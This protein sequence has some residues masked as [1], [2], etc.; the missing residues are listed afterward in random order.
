MAGIINVWPISGRQLIDRVSLASVLSYTSPSWSGGQYRQLELTLQLTTTDATVQ[1][2]VSLTGLS[3]TYST[4]IMF[5]SGAGSAGGSVDAATW[6]TGIQTNGELYARIL[7][8]PGAKRAIFGMARSGA[9]AL[10]MAGEHTDTASLPTALVVTFT[11]TPAVG[12]VEVWGW[13]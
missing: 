5:V 10:Q 2:K 7:I 12:L 4:E 1:P 13:P 11:T 6:N 8:A 3:G 9:I